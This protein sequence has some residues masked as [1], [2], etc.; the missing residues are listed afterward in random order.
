MG[1]FTPWVK[2]LQTTIV[3]RLTFSAKAGPREALCLHRN[4]SLRTC[5][6]PGRHCIPTDSL[7]KYMCG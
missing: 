5:P 2:R 3:G 1:K 7:G 6:G 4:A